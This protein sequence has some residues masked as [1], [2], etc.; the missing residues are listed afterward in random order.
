MK[1]TI[2]IFLFLVVASGASLA[3][4][5]QSG[6]TFNVRAFGAKGDG[7]TN[8][9]SAVALAN[10]AT[11]ASPGGILYF[12]S[13]TYPVDPGTVTIATNSITIRGDGVGRSVLKNR[14]AGSAI[15]LNN[16]SA[17]THSILITNLSISGFG[18]G[19]TDIGISVTS[20]SNEPFGLTV[21]SVTISNVAG[22]G[23]YVSNNLFTSRFVDVDV[24]VLA[25]GTNGIDISGGADI[26]LENCY[27]HSVGTG[28][29]A[30]RIHAGNVAMIGC[31]GIDSGTTADWLVLGDST[32][33]GDPSDR[34][35][36]AILIACNVE[37][38]TNRGVYAKSGSYVSEYRGV[39]F[40]S[41]TSGTVTA[42]KY[43]FVDTG[44]RGTWDSAS[45]FTLSGSAAY[46]NGKAIN[47]N[48]AP[49][50]QIGDTTLTDY[51]DT[52]SA[53]VVTL[54][55]LSVQLVPGST[56]T[57]IKATRA[58]ITAL[59][60]S[61]LVGDL[62]GANSFAGNAARIILQAGTAARPTLASTDINTTG[63][64][65]PSSGT[66]IG[67]TV[68]GTRALTV[69]SGQSYGVV[70][71]LGNKS[72]SFTV[73]FASGSSVTM[74]ATGNFSTVTFSNIKAGGHYVLQITQN[75]GTPR[76]WTP[77]TIFKYPGGISG[78][79]LTGSSGAVDVFICDSLDGTNLVCNG[80]FDV[81]NP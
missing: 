15:T 28:G 41:A 1:R 57:A 60:S 22:R 70:Q 38:Y 8:D 68:S 45:S 61:G 23:I 25:A 81:K 36:R 53:A 47:S 50:V 4:T 72:G 2:L 27:V 66:A 46:T 49:F 26:V 20:A 74:T 77:P 42:I 76:T 14:S 67:F 34:Y 35:A 73:D 59:E 37:A 44:Q 6:R 9:T 43:D 58:Q 55:S 21:D 69:D 71:N 65:F 79:I 10:A 33:T 54:P 56:N 62:T 30:Y 11:V 63:M 52:G 16:A 29:A 7:T 64:Y 24:S 18:S 32:G 3:Q 40:I 13:G 17:I 78:N 75:V 80:L 48:G 12:P 39:T 31:N 19:S 5:S 51:Y